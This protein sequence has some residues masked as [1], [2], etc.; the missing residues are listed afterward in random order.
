[1]EPHL[2]RTDESTANN[3][4]V[5]RTLVAVA[6]HRGRRSDLALPFI[7]IITKSGSSDIAALA[8][9]LIARLYKKEPHN[10]AAIVET[11][12]KEK[13]QHLRSTNCDR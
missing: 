10:G 4:F 6:H 2:V 9:S 1:M 11:A 3:A 5:G 7:V 8:I 13:N 12:T